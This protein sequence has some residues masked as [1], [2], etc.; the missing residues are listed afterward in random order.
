MNFLNLFEDTYRPESWEDFHSNSVC[1][2]LMRFN[3]LRYLVVVRIESDF[4]HPSCVWVT[5]H[6]AHTK[7]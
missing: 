3:S 2:P 5:S 6:L 1:M 4:V 7:Y